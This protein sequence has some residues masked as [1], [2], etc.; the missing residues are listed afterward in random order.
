MNKEFKNMLIGLFVLILY[1]LYDYIFVYI[2]SFF[3]INFIS[4]NLLQ[5]II[6]SLTAEFILIIVIILIYRKKITC[7]LKQFRKIHF[8]NYIKYWF[9]TLG[10]ML[11]SNIIISMI[12]SIDTS[13]NQEAIVATFEKSPIYTCILTMIFAP[14]LEELVFRLSFRKMFKTDILFIII[15]GL[16]F[17]FM[18]VSSPSSIAEILYII[19]YSIPGFIFAYT[20]TKSDNIFVPI[21]LHF[22]HNS[23]MMLFQIILVLL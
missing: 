7:D 12:T 4:L 9:L 14:I 6:V 18:H 8:S 3:N 16:F 23:A 1:L 17:G 5:K 22:I 11:I 2:L 13:T 21:G 15:S 19:P 20:L 10:I